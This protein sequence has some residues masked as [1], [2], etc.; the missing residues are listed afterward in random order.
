MKCL[1]Q[2][3][4]RN[5]KSILLK[6]CGSEGLGA[7]S[8]QSKKSERGRTRVEMH[9]LLLE[10]IQGRQKRKREMKQERSDESVT[11]FVSRR[12]RTGKCFKWNKTKQ[13]K[14]FPSSFFSSFIL[15]TFA[16][17][18]S[19]FLPSWF[20]SANH[21]LTFHLSPSATSASSDLLYSTFFCFF[22]LL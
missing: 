16:F 22:H 21:S 2:N 9:V 19:S 15:L 14:S 12:S 18:F 17:L 11:R 20:V 4:E 5:L 10:L 13:T 3:K 1:L 7:D 6:V 8:K